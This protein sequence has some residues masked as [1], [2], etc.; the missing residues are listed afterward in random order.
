VL[1]RRYGSGHS[2]RLRALF[3]Q[4]GL[5][6]AGT[7]DKVPNTRR[8][9]MLGELARDRGVL[10]QLHPRLFDAYWAQGRDIG[11]EPVLVEEGVG[12]GLDEAEIVNA[13]R[14]GRYLDRI[15]AGT[16]AAIDLGAG[17]VPAWLIDDRVLVP[18]AQPH[19]VFERVLERFGHAPV[20][21]PTDRPV[22]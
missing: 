5:P 14:D 6:Y 22:D 19:E 20:A 7:I 10:H 15:E 13:L 8:T 1:E 17:G 3:E 4:A 12:V 18:G 2:Q 16:A 21:H 9:L 11:S